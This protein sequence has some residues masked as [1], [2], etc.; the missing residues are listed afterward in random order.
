M[1]SW[2]NLIKANLALLLYCGLAAADDWPQWMGPTRDGEWRE[3]GVIEALDPA[4]PRILWRSPIGWGYSGPAVVGDRVYALDYQV[5]EGEPANSPSA[6]AALQGRERIVCLDVAT[7][8]QVWEFGY[9]RPYL[10]SY[11]KGPRCTPTVADGKVYSLGAEGDL[12]C[13]DA[14]T[15]APVWHKLLTEEYAVE[16]PLWGFA[17][18]PLVD[19]DVLYCVVGGPGSVAVAFNKETGEELWRA[20]DADEPGYCPPKIVTAG[21]VRQ[22]LIWS[23]LA[24]NGLDPASG[25]LLWDVK[26]EPGYAMSVAAPQL[27]GDLLYTSGIGD[28]AVVVKLGPPDAPATELWRGTPRNAV[29]CS[30]STPLIADGVVYGADCRSG[31][32]RAVDLATG[33]RLWESFQPT[34]GDGEAGHG[35]AFLVKNGDRYFLFSETGDLVVARLSREG[36]EELSRTHVIE[37]TNE[38]FGR[39]VVWS[40]PAFAN[41]KMFVRND[42]EM[43]CVDLTAE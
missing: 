22:L 40:H 36:Y 14:T 38:A 33:D 12:Y 27:A 39:P 26:L 15:G 43:V 19:G 2:N 9:D 35:T 8:E 3:S 37:P 30:N 42:E 5:A 17:A 29:Y 6:R 31:G 4:D 1:M 23:P 41:R 34:T 18:H 32:L 11:P 21:G 13:L 16:T 7:G 24:L 10:L 25:A 28:A 20:L